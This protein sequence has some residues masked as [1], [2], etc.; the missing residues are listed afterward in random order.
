MELRHAD[1]TDRVPSSDSPLTHDGPA[2]IRRRAHSSARP[3]EPG[4]AFSV[5]PGIYLPGRHGARIE[6]I[7]VCT[8]HG[9]IRLN[10]TSRELGILA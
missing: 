5:E 10:Q 9:G 1:V 2:P 7:C 3:L 4:M 8:P 6:D